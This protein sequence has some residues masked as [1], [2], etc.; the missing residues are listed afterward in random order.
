MVCIDVVC[1]G[2]VVVNS[3]V[4]LYSFYLWLVLVVA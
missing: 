2:L 1:L 3:V 4:V